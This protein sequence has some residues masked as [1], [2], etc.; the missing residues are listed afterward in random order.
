MRLVAFL[1][2]SLVAL[3]PRVSSAQDEHTA[4]PGPLATTT[5]V[6]G[7]LLVPGAGHAV[8]GD[9]ESGW[10]LAKV[11]GLGLGVAGAGALWLA[12]TGASR[13]AG[14][15]PVAMMIAG[16]GLMIVPWWADIYGSA[17]GGRGTGIPRVDLPRAEID[18]MYAHV[19]D[20]R[21]EF[22]HFAA[23]RADV[24]V[25]SFRLRPLLWVSTDTGNQRGRLEVAYR[26]RGPGAARPSGD[27][28]AF[29]VRGAA[30]YHLYPEESFWVA[31]AEVAVAGRYDMARVSPSLKGSFAELSLGLALERIDYDVAG[32]SDDYTDL[33]VGGFAYGMYL[34]RRG[35]LAAFYE[36]RRDELTGGISPG[37]ENGSGFLGHL[38]GRAFFYVTD[39]FGITAEYA[40]GAAHV[41]Q[42][43][44][45]V[46]LGAAP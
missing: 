32:A 43:G 40:A 24:G 31:T 8:A 36:H 2:A 44:L 7:G 38:G 28:S 9:W 1:V 26:L 23:F 14:G 17:G 6:F 12:A 15:I 29:E 4:D 19:R 33:L 25:A 37:R 18:A 30:G 45:R 42:I 11:R 16:S 3:A 10:A 27:G 34:G 46:K 5:A 21:F 35:E 39:R 13:R 20:P 22:S 41:A